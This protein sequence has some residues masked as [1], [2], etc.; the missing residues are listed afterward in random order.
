ME[1]T[2]LAAVLLPPPAER[3]VDNLSRRRDA[4]E[5]LESFVQHRSVLLDVVGLAQGMTEGPSQID[6]SRRLHLL[7]IASNDGNADGGDA[8]PF[9]FSLHQPDR[10]VA[11]GSS[12]SKEND[13]DA[14]LYQSFG[15]A[16]RRLFYKGG[17]VGAINMPHE[18]V[19]ALR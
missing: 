18:T 11:Y 6:R 16:A 4:V 9:N 7:R 5:C 14:V 12:G 15:D 1:K 2:S 17:D 8:R 13:V 19:V 3:Q 10:L